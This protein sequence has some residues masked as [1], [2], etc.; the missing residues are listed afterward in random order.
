[1]NMTYSWIAIYK[2]DTSLCQ[3][4]GSHEHQFSDIHQDKLKTFIISN[5]NN[6]ITLNMDTG[7]FTINGSEIAIDKISNK[8]YDYRLIHFKRVRVNIGT[9]TIDEN[10]VVKYFIGY[11]VTI[12]DVNKKVM[13]CAYKN[14][15]NIHVE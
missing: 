1:M 7:V 2:D 15:F 9:Q 14:S 6:R 4:D 12:K 8:D 5:K 10:R 3:F 13:I 11:Q